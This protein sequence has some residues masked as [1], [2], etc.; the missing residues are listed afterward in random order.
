M[1]LAYW[2]LHEHPFRITMIPGRWSLLPHQAHAARQLHSAFRAGERV[3]LL[4]GPHGI[5]KT[6]LAQHITGESEAQGVLTAWAACVPVVGSQALYQ[7]LLADLGQPFLLRST[8]ELRMQ[9]VEHLLPLVSEGKTILIVV[10]EAQHIPLNILEEL[11]PLI[12][13]ITPVGQPGVQL[14]LVGTD[15]LLSQFD[16]STTLALSHW[17]GCRAVLKPME[18]SAAAVFLQQNWK[19]AGGDPHRQASDEA[20]SLMVEMAGGLPLTMNR[21]AGHSFRLAQELKLASLDAELVWEAGNE[22]GLSL[23][24]DVE[25]AVPMPSLLKNSA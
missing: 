20:W 1:D 21:L 12:E 11:R 9:L 19:Q 16:A 15:Q 25:P 3:A 18:V 17:V 5:G 13:M 10:D 6:L 2:G 4:V 22:L 24:E 14:L 8:V 23:E 7:M